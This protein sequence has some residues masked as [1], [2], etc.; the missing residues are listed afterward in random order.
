M[1]VRLA[2]PLC[3]DRNQNTVGQSPTPANY[4]RE[5]KPVSGVG[6]GRSLCS[7]GAPLPISGVIT[8]G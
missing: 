2:V 5:M 6:P 4:G 3:I 7:C 1:R 8:E